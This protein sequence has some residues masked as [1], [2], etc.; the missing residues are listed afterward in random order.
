VDTG[1]R[2]GINKFLLVQWVAPLAS[3]AP[4]MI[5][6]ILFVLRSRP[7]AG[8][9]TLISSKVNQWTLLIATLPLV[10]AISRGGN[11]PLVL[12][13]RQV[14]EV[15]LTAAQSVFAIAVLANLAIT[16]WEAIGLLTLFLAQFGFEN[17]AV[18]YGFSFAYL[19]LFVAIVLFDDAAR[20]GL[21]AALK[22]TAR[23][24]WKQLDRN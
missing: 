15:L 4:E 19:A 7:T 20:R 21:V 2:F 6:A 3:E 10:Y 18:R 24:P 17:T 5:V 1:T 9:G 12:D 22:Q 14:E 11:H 8:L 23:P 13:E 16:K